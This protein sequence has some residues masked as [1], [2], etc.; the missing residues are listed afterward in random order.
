MVMAFLMLASLSH[1]VD[2][3]SD[4]PVQKAVAFLDLISAGKVDTA[5]DSVFKGSSVPA[6]KP[7]EYDAVKKQTSMGLSVYG[8]PLGYD[9]V[10][11]TYYGT[12]VVRVI[13]DLKMAKGP[14]TWIF[15]FYRPSSKW[16]ALN[17]S[18]NDQLTGISN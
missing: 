8:K 11:E 9:F 4:V 2:K 7:Q 1:A 5:F 18:F 12:S 13:Y 15:Y 3:K 6:D 14:L 17:V 10:S 16:F